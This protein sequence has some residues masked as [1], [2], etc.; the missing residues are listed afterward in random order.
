M[1]AA[2]SV[3]DA[4]TATTPLRGELSADLAG[5]VAVVHLDHDIARAVAL[6]VRR[7]DDRVVEVPAAA[8]DD[9]EQERE[10]DHRDDDPAATTSGPGGF[11]CR[12]TAADRSDPDGFVAHTLGRRFV[13]GG[14]GVHSVATHGAG[15]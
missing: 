4:C 2:A 10:R 13:N 7:R 3:N 5:R 1:S 11:P 6:E 12:A 8:R 9:P 14:C 15:A